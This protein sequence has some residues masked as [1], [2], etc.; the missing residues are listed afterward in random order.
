MY[1]YPE[2]FFAGGA[3]LTSYLLRSFLHTPKAELVDQSGLVPMQLTKFL[4]VDAGIFA[5]RPYYAFIPILDGDG[6][7]PV[8]FQVGD[9]GLDLSF[10]DSEEFGKIPI[11]GVATAFVIK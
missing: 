11:G 7:K 2:V 9:V 6:D 5:S 8:R 4:A 1:Y 3:N 10:A